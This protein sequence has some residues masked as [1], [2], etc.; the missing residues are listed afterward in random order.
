M[1]VDAE[2]AGEEF[3]VDDGWKLVESLP[4]AGHGVDPEVV[5]VNGLPRTGYGGNSH[6]DEPAEDQQ[7]LFSWA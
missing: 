2:S 7:S 5:A 3:L 1:G 4:R 6:G